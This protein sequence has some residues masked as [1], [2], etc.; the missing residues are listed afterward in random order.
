MAAI[1][2]TTGR[3]VNAAAVAASTPIHMAWGGGDDSWGATP[4]NPS[5]A[6]T[7]L[8][9]EIGRRVA[10]E[11]AFVNPNPAGSIVMPQ[12]NYTLSGT[13]T[14]HLYLRFHFAFGDAI[15]ETIRELGVFVGGA[16]T[17]GNEAK[18]YLLPAEVATPGSLYLLENVPEFVRYAGS[19]QQYSF[20][21]AF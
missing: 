15:D 11:I 16:P 1:L 3:A 8:L 21:V 20:V 14:R 5:T 7:G 12:G 17:V 6:A 10:T 9:D 18:A 19:R 13:P 2:T 4:P